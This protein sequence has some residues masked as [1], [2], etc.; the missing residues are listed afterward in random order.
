MVQLSIGSDFGFEPD[1]EEMEAATD[2]RGTA[3]KALPTSSWLKSDGPRA[4]ERDATAAFARLGWIELVAI[5]QTGL[6]HGSVLGLACSAA[7]ALGY[8]GAPVA[9]A[10]SVAMPA[11]IFR[12]CGE[13]EARNSVFDQFVSGQ[14]VCGVVIEPSPDTVSPLTAES[15]RE[16]GFRLSGQTGWVLPAT[17]DLYIVSFSHEGEQFIG[18][19]G[20]KASG[21]V[22]EPVDLADGTEASYLRFDE[23]V[24]EDACVLARGKAVAEVEASVREAGLMTTAAQLVGT[25]RRAL[26]L[27]VEYAVM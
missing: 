9:F 11:T 26:E 22:V 25:S 21:L 14:V 7:E 12:L 20:A 10:A 23:V 1:S 19:V 17:A 24:I 15:L 2:L 4:T 8:L 5:E 18:Y 13:S 3:F 16:G 27:T 6:A